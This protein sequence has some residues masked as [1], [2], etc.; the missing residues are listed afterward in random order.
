MIA[1]FVSPV[2]DLRRQLEVMNER[3]QQ[4]RGQRLQH[5]VVFLEGSAAPEDPPEYVSSFGVLCL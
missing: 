5:N 1:V 4:L 3:I 2:A